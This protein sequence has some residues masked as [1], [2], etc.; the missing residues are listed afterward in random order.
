VSEG[1]KGSGA[2]D[3]NIVGSDIVMRLKRNRTYMFISR[4]LKVQFNKAGSSTTPRTK[5]KVV[6]VSTTKPFSIPGPDLNQ[7]AR[8]EKQFTS[9]QDHNSSLTKDH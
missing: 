9:A 5:S 1:I 7:L 6:I 4:S 2:S 3:S 8:V